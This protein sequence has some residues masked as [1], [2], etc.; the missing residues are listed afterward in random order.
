MSSGELPSAGIMFAS[1]VLLLLLDGHA[2][3]LGFESTWIDDRTER[4]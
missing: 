4:T 3:V 1:A 2:D